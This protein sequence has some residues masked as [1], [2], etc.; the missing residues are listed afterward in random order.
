MDVH[1]KNLQETERRALLTKEQR[2]SLHTKLEQIGAVYKGSAFLKDAYICPESVN[3]LSEV[4]MNEVGSYSLR[5][6]SKKVGTKTTVELNL[7]V[8]TTYG[9]HNSWKE[10]EVTIDSYEEIVNIL[11][12]LGFKAFLNVEK[13]RSSYQYGRFNLEVEDI[14]DYGPILEIET[15]SNINSMANAKKSIDDL[16]E[17]LGI[18]N[19]QIVPKSV[20]NIIMKEK[21]VF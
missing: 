21:A 15:F 20:T 8:I 3:S 9:D 18:A 16:F 6:R 5:V 4:E 19:K 2:Q 12:M 11:K 7:K 10:Y 17:T 13:T 1:K 14:K